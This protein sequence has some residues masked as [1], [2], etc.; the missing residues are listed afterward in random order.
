[1]AAAVFGYDHEIVTI[2]CD[3]AVAAR[4][5]V[6]GVPESVIFSM[7]ARLLT[8]ELPSFWKQ[9]VVFNEAS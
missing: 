6:H 1:M 4:R 8:T 9:K 2:Y 5:N 7:H 3:P